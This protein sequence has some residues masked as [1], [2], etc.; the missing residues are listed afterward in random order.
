MSTKKSTNTVR[1]LILHDSKDQAERL[2]SEL[3]NFGYATR[4]HLIEDEG[5]LLDALSHGLWD[6]MLARP[7]TDDIG[8]YAAM[9]HIQA[10]EKDI[11]TI[12]LSDDGDS[13]TI[14]EG[15]KNGARDVVPIDE[16]ERL[17]FVFQR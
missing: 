3:R 17:K 5:D 16:L 4:A 9:R 14:T 11:P 7:E 6:I 8:A 12:I 1:L 2:I 10:K 15:L 13:D